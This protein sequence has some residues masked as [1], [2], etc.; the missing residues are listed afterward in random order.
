MTRDKSHKG[1]KLRKTSHNNPAYDRMKAFVGQAPGGGGG[2][3]FTRDDVENA[4][5]NK[6][7]HCGKPTKHMFCS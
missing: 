6:C 2:S 7:R 4:A 5:K 1:S 3:A